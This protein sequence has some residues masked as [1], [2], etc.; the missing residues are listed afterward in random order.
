MRITPLSLALATLM[1]TP[2]TSVWP[3]QN[4]SSWDK[5]PSEFLGIPLHGDFKAQTP[6]CPDTPERQPTLCRSSTSTTDRFEIRGLPYVPISLGY[7][8][9]VTLQGNAIDELMLTGNASSLELVDDFLR[10]TFGQPGSS[11]SHR[12][13]L[14]SGATYEIKTS[15]WKGKK[16]AV[17]FQRD[18]DDLS[19]YAVIISR[20]SDLSKSAAAAT[21]SQ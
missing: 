4:F 21:P 9:F 16:V 17:H 19:R 20:S 2:S 10:D 14:E 3:A 13:Q 5:E 7:Q 6:A 12:I 18:E 1:I 11:L 15:T 8:V